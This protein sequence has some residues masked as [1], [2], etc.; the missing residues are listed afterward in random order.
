MDLLMVEAVVP[1]VWFQIFLDSCQ[2]QLQHLLLVKEHQMLSQ[3]LLV[4]VVQN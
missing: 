4:L 3:L 2:Q 1:V